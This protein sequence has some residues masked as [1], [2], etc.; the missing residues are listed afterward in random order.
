MNDQKQKPLWLRTLIVLGVLFI[1][2][3]ILVGGYYV[4]LYYLMP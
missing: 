4:L 2:M 1:A 3:N